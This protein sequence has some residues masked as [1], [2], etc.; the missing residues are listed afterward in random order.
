MCLSSAFA[1]QKAKNINLEVK[2]IKS[3]RRWI[4]TSSSNE[5]NIFLTL[6]PSLNL[7]IMFVSPFIKLT[8]SSLVFAAKLLRSRKF[9]VEITS[10][11]KKAWEGRDSGE[12]LEWG[13]RVIKADSIAVQ[14]LQVSDGQNKAVGAERTNTADPCQTYPSSAETCSRSP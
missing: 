14:R 8:F 3:S 9:S 10:E 5:G 1:N 7:S 13:W 4:R 12:G 11:E 6:S 2:R